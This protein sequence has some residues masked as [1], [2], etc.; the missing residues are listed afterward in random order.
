MTETPVRT[1][2]LQLTSPEAIA[3]QEMFLLAQS[4]ANV[5]ASSDLVPAEYRGKIANVMIAT[6][7]ARRMG[8]D[9]LQV[10]QNLYIVHGKPGWSAQFLIAM[11]NESGEYTSIRY[12]FTGEKGA[13][14]WGCIAYCMEKATGEEISGTEVTIAMAKAE[15]WYGKNGS[16][17]K[18]IPEQMLRYRSATYLVRAT[19]PQ[20]A[21]GL[22]TKEEIEDVVT[23]GSFRPR[24]NLESSELLIDEPTEVEEDTD[25]G[26]F[27][28]GDDGAPENADAARG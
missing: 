20:L 21:M 2:D 26:S 24:G 18:T 11:F 23:T 13:D 17:W 19:A 22:Q 3:E 1:K 10:M 9:V 16:K 5:Y 15:G 7:M 4:R 28:F 8:A 6:N 27:L 12:R 25:S 14:S